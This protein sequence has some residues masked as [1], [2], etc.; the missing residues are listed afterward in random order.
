MHL[1]WLFTI[2]SIGRVNSR[3]WN[4]NAVIAKSLAS[5]QHL[6]NQPTFSFS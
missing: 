4:G 5:P 1:D 3:V 6:G 2:S